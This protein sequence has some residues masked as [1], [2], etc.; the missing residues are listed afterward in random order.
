MRLVYGAGY[1]T[2]R[3]SLSL[4]LEAWSRY[5]EIDVDYFMLLPFEI[6]DDVTNMW[7]DAKNAV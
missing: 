1:A 3:L 4:A 6:Q 5:P 2:R 7:Q